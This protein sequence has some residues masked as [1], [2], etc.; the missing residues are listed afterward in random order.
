MLT[1]IREKTHG[2]IAGFIIT[3][4]VIP[5]ALWGTYSYFEGGSDINVAEVGGVEISQQAY[6]LALEQYRG[7][8]DPSVFDSPEFK[9]RVL[10]GLVDE[11]LMASNTFDQGYRTSDATLG[12]LIREAPELQ[13]NGQFDPELYQA[14]LRQQGLTQQAFEERLRRTR[15]SRQIVDGFTESAVISSSQ[16]DA[17]LRL[18]LQTR[19][20]D[21]VA[22]KPQ[23][24]IASTQIS[25]EQ[26]EQ[27]YASN[28]DEYKTPEAVRIEYVRL[29]ASDFAKKYQ[30]TEE[31]LRGAYEQEIARYATPEQWRVSH[32]LFELPEGATQ[33]AVQQALEQARDIE[34]QLRA[35]ADFTALAK[36][37]S[38]DSGTAENGGDLGFVGAGTLP[39]ELEQAVSAIEVGSITAPVLTSYGYHIAK[40]TEH[41][42]MARKSYEEAK[43]EVEKNVRERK[44]EEEFYEKFEELSNI[45]YEQSDSLEPAATALGLEIQQSGW[46]DRSGGSGVTTQP[47]VIDA[48][49]HPEV[50]IESRNS[51]AI[52]IGRNELIALRVTG[53]REPAVR[54]LAEVRA[55][56]EQRLRRESA[57]AQAAELGADVLTK[58]REGAVL[59][60]LIQKQSLELK[61]SGPISRL[62]SQGVDRR[63]VDTVFQARSPE[64]EQAVYGEAD[65]GEQGYAVF[66]LNGIQLGESKDADEALKQRAE[67][68]LRQRLGQEHFASYLARLRKG[69]EVKIFPDHL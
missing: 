68:V 26:I 6:R 55:Q 41:T 49:F 36:K 11:T 29:A 23:K 48:A 69:A 17:L 62:Q 50:L 66:A 53:H 18:W 58:L 39:K 15:I 12:Q 7:N 44:G 28:S 27:A 9:R 10:D 67:N 20:F 4:I 16:K 33:E 57:R 40:L 65:L 21:Y 54:S 25:N 51:D 32:I 8:V 46:F 5:F 42:P 38:S 22:I 37:H 60:Q 43:A 52:E 3:L 14:I 13:R 45:I 1:A 64:G 30:P 19:E 31:E 24:F 34:G 59:R 47:K 56:I 63:I 61:Q 2:I 35:G